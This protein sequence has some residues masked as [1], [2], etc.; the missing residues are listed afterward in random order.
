M[1]IINFYILDFPE[2]Y[3]KNKLVMTEDTCEELWVKTFQYGNKNARTF[4][5]GIRKKQ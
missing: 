2:R 3:I 5:S 4:E 1:A